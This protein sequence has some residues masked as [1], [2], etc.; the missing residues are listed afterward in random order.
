MTV[1]FCLESP[2]LL[3]YSPHK[4][5]EQNTVGKIESFFSTEEVSSVTQI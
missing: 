1:A 2:L 4:I 3:R 5:H